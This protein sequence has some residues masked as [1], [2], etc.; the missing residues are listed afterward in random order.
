MSQL[1]SDVDENKE[2]EGSWNSSKETARSE[3]TTDNLRSLYGS[4]L[5]GCNKPARNICLF[6]DRAIA[7][8]MPYDPLDP[9]SAKPL[10][11]PALDREVRIKEL[12]SKQEKLL[13][14]MRQKKGNV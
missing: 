9:H 5:Y 11:S 8:L 3:A 10:Y 14:E 2:L 6:T 1:N 7:S 13:A 4:M 12:L